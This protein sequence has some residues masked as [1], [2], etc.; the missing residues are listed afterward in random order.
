MKTVEKG[1]TVVRTRCRPRTL[2]EVCAQMLRVCDRNRGDRR[3]E[4]VGDALRGLLRRVTT[5]NGPH[6]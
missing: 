6:N 1:E 4:A 5:A 3:F 2:H